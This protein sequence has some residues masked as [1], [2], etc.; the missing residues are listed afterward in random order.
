MGWIRLGRQNTP[1]HQVH[2]RGLQ[3]PTEG[4]LLSLSPATWF[5][6]SEFSLWQASKVGN[7]NADQAETTVLIKIWGDEGAGEPRDSVS[8]CGE[9]I[10]FIN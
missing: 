2:S 3:S 1:Q 6:P 4:L 9:G 7:L 10:V 8:Q 5:Q